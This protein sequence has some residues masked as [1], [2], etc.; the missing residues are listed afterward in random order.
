MG[1][2]SRVSFPGQPTVTRRSSCIVVALLCCSLAF[3]TSAHAA[4]AWVIWSY[5]T[6]TDSY[7][8]AMAFGTLSAGR[9]KG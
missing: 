5:S 7:E 4:C 8:V 3:A 6:T 2:E 9:R 1:I